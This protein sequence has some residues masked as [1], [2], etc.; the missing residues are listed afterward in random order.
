MDARHY[1]HPWLYVCYAKY[2]VPSSAN[3]IQNRQ[4]QNGRR[5]KDYVKYLISDNV[6]T[7]DEISLIVISCLAFVITFA[8]L[9]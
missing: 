6:V 5:E 4:N 1:E 7:H 9:S 8:L 2:V 3:G